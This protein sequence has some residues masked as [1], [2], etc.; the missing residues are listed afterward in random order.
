MALEGSTFT[1]VLPD[2]MREALRLR[3]EANNR[4]MSGEAREAI[5]RHLMAEGAKEFA[6]QEV[7]E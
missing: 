5:H 3:A 4:T 6:P 1:F 2:L 7:S